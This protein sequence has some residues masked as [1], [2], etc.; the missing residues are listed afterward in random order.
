MKKVLVF[1]ALAALAV[2]GWGT[3]LY[4][5][6]TET[7]YRY[8]PGLGGDPNVAPPTQFDVTF[9]D[10][11]IPVS[12]LG[13]YTWADITRVTVGIRRG[14][15]AP[16]T[17]VSVYYTTFT[18][19]VTPPDLNID[20]PPTLIQTFSLPAGGASWVTQLLVAGDGV[21]T[22]F[23]V[24]LNM[25]F[26]GDPNTPGPE[27][28]SFAIG[29]QIHNADTLNGWRI[30]SGPDGN[31]DIFWLYDTDLSN[32]E[33]GPYYFGGNPV[34]AFYIKVEGEGVVPEPASLGLLG[35][36]LLLRRR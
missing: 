29:V 14:P 33:K 28:G 17:D 20:T 22:L 34:A 10:V 26:I 18:T 24:P 23:T 31:A 19:N 1:M 27:F 6:T 5:R 32:P 30:T 4:D 15:S 35:L 2:P 9:D 12:R 11:P 8:N 3:V 21:N 36:A 13:G 25:D 16:A 7:G